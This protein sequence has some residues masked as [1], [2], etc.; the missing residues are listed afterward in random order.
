VKASQ[1]DP[2]KPKAPAS[3]ADNK[4]QAVQAWANKKATWR[5]KD[6][7]ETADCQG[8]GRMP[9][10]QFGSWA[11]P[12]AC[13]RANTQQ[14]AG[15]ELAGDSD[16]REGACPKPELRAPRSQSVSAPAACR[17]SGAFPRSNAC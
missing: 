1:I 5:E 12:G 13:L 11:L 10:A 2:A 17:R 15:P 14:S 4:G 8:H 16:L 6:G 3:S 9:R 7:R